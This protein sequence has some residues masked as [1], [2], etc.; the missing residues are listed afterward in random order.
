MIPGHEPGRAIRL[1]L[2]SC[3]KGGGVHLEQ[4]AYS[5]TVGWYCERTLSV[6]RSL[7]DDL[8]RALRMSN[9]LLPPSSEGSDTSCEPADADV[10]QLTFPS[11]V[12]PSAEPP[13]TDRRSG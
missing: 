2:E 3:P 1:R 8:A 5:R 7:L 11:P 10:N 13:R 12:S 9:C 4:V 6:P